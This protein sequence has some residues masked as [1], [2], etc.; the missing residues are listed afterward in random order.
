LFN[1][2]TNGKKKTVSAL[3]FNTGL[4]VRISLITEKRYADLD[5]GQPGS[6]MIGTPPPAKIYQDGQALPR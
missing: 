1:L 2:Y 5:P 6:A 4:I 3:T